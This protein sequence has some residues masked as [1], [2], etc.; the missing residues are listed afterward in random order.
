V[1]STLITVGVVVSTFGFLNLAILASPRMYQA[2]AAD[3]VFF[4]AAARLDSRFHVPAVALTIQAVWAVLLLSSRTYG[5]LLDYVVFGDWIFFGLVGATLFVYRR[6]PVGRPAF[7]VP[8]YPLV[9]LF[10]VGVAAF[11]V[12][13]SVAADIRNAGLG[14]VLIVAGIPVFFAW[15]R[16]HRRE[17]RSG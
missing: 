17:R 1:G 14:A 12:I 3:G 15:R 16:R 13:S 11:T 5:Q 8:F 7:L 10:F 4:G 2:M 6:E 9:P